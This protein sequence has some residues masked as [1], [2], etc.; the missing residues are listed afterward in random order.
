M[1]EPDPSSPAFLDVPGECGDSPWRP[2]VGRIVQLYEQLVVREKCIVNFVGILD[3][4][5][6][7]VI[8]GRLL[9][10]PNLSCVYKRPVNA[11]LLSERNDVEFRRGALR[12]GVAGEGE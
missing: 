6:G 12:I 1:V 10:Q 7:E 3:V 5:D 11:S 8:G 9:L 2:T 4:I